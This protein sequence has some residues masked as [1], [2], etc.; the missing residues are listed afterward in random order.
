MNARI[1]CCQCG[2][3]LGDKPGF[4]R[5]G[6]VTSTYCPECEAEVYRELARMTLDGRATLCR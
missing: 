5:P 2:K 6:M 4:E 1:I 3:Y